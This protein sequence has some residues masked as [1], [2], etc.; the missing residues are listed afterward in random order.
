MH[1]LLLAD[2]PFAEHE[3]ALIERVAAG[4]TGEGVRVTVAIPKRTETQFSLLTDPIRYSDRGLM[5]THRIRAEQ[6]AAAVG[7][8]VS[9][10]SGLIDVVHAFGGGAW[11]IAGTLAEIFGSALAFELWRGGLTDRLEG[12]SPP[13]GVVAAC[14]APD[15][16]IE[17][18]VTSSGTDLSIRLTPWGCY[19]PPAPTPVFRSGAT[20]S[21]VFVSSGRDGDQCR[22]A[23]EGACR[24]IAQSTDVMMFVAA[25]AVNRAGLWKIAE[26]VGVLDRLTLIDR[27][28]DRRDLILCC[29]MIVYPDTRHEQRTILLDAMAHGLVIVAAGD[30]LVSVIVDG[31]TVKSPESVTTVA[32]QEAVAG[33]LADR[34]AAIALGLSA[35]EHIRKNRRASA[36]IA[37]LIDAYTWLAG[38][39]SVPIDSRV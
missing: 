9:K 29:D 15:R 3:R 13:T 22:Q 38:A 30:P 11:T 24:V 27:L 20:A 19:S 36:H 28:E 39:D 8:S 37:S 1:V 4:V 31:V 25:D 33:V 6:V 32:W 21:M 14:F 16:P 34:S 5:L 23:F 7:G 35:R 10:A 2:A 26:R 17:R 12:I 18:A